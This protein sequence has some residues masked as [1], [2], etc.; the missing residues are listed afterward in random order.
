MCGYPN[1]PSSS[2]GRH[3]RR[4][5]GGGGGSASSAN[6]QLMHPPPPPPQ[7]Q[8]PSNGPPFPASL[9]SRGPA[10]PRG[11]IGPPPALGVGPP[12]ANGSNSNGNSA[13]PMH[14]MSP[15]PSM[16]MQPMP[17]PAFGGHHHHNGPPMMM[18]N[19]MSG[20]LPTAHATLGHAVTWGGGGPPP[21]PHH[22]GMME[23]GPG[24]MVGPMPPP[25]MMMMSG[26][27]EYHHP[28]PADPHYGYMMEAGGP[29]P[30]GPGGPLRSTSVPM[31]AGGGGMPPANNPVNQSHGNTWIQVMQQHSMCPALLNQNDHPTLLRWDPFEDL[32]WVGTQ[33]GRLASMQFTANGGLTDYTRF[34]LE[35]SILDEGCDGESGGCYSPVSNGGVVATYNPVQ[36]LLFDQS[37]VISVTPH[38]IHFHTRGGVRHY[39]MDDKT[40]HR[41]GSNGNVIRSAEFYQPNPSHLVVGGEK[42]T[43]FFVDMQAGSL[44][45]FID[46]PHGCSVL[47]NP[48]RSSVL[49]MGGTDGSISFVDGRVPKVLT[50]LNAH[51]REITTLSSRDHWLI[52]C[53]KREGPGSIVGPDVFLKVFDI[54]TLRQALPISCP[55]GAYMAK[56]HPALPSSVVLLNV[57][58]M[59]QQADF[60]PGASQL[61][62]P[63]YYKT[64]AVGHPRGY[65]NTV[66]ARSSMSDSSTVGSCGDGVGSSSSGG[67]KEV[68]GE[69]IDMDIAS[70]GGT[71]ALLDNNGWIHL[72]QTVSE[73]AMQSQGMHARVNQYSNPTAPHNPRSR[74][75]VTGMLDG[76]TDNRVLAE[77]ARAVRQRPMCVMDRRT[78]NIIYN[79]QDTMPLWPVGLQPMADDEE[80]RQYNN[81]PGAYYDDEQDGCRRLRPPQ[82]MLPAV[83]DAARGQGIDTTKHPDSPRAASRIPVVHMRRS[84]TD[85]PIEGDTI[86]W[87]TTT[88]MNEVSEELR[89]M[90]RD[91]RH[92]QPRAESQLSD[93]LTESAEEEKDPVTGLTRIPRRFQFTEIDYG[94]NYNRFPFAKYNRSRFVCGLDN[95]YGGSNWN[96]IEFC[97]N[98]VTHI[99]YFIRPLMQAAEKHVCT[100]VVCVYCELGYVFRMMEQLMFASNRICQC[101]RLLR[102]LKATAP[103]ELREPIDSNHPALS[104]GHK[105]ILLLKHV[106]LSCKRT[107]S[108][109]P[110]SRGSSPLPSGY[111]PPLSAI[112]HHPSANIVSRLFGLSPPH[113]VPASPFVTLQ[114]PSDEELQE[115]VE[116]C[117]DA[118]AA[119]ATS[120]EEDE[121]GEPHG[122]TTQESDSGEGETDTDGGTHGEAATEDSDEADDGHVLKPDHAAFVSMLRPSLVGGHGSPPVLLMDICP[123]TETQAAFW[124]VGGRDFLPTTLWLGYNDP[125]DRTLITDVS[126][127]KPY[128]ISAKNNNSN[129][130]PRPR[131]NY[132][133]YELQSVAL[134]VKDRPKRKCPQ[135]HLV[136]IT[137]IPPDYHTDTYRTSGTAR[138]PSM[139]SSARGPPPPAEG[140]AAVGAGVGVAGTPAGVGVIPTPPKGTPTRFMSPGVISHPSP[141]YQAS[142][143]SSQ[144]PRPFSYA[145]AVAGRSYAAAASSVGSGA[146]S[147][148]GDSVSPSPPTSEGATSTEEDEEED[149]NWMVLND[150][151]IT[152]SARQE[153]VDFGPEWRTPVLAVYVQKRSLA[154]VAVHDRQLSTATPLSS[155]TLHPDG[156]G[157]KWGQYLLVVI[158]V[159][160][161]SS[162]TIASTLILSPPRITRNF[163]PLTEK[164]IDRLLHGGLTVA[165]DAEFVAMGLASVEIRED[166]SKEVS[167]PGEMA[168]GRVSVLRADPMNPDDGDEGIKEG[169]PFIDHYLRIDESE[170]KDFVTR[171]SG[172]VPGDL[173]PKTSRHWLVSSKSVC[174][175]LRFLVDCGC[176][177]VGHGLSTDFR[178]INL[179]V[180]QRNIRDTVELF[181]LPGQRY[182]SLKFLA[183]HL[184]GSSIQTD[185]HCSVEDA[186]AAL[187]LYRKYQELEAEGTLDDKIKQLYEIGRQQGWK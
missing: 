118:E 42:R 111:S 27:D 52:S 159:W 121:E 51:P 31:M 114:L 28:P 12:P 174:E 74:H 161:C 96:G 150:F 79:Y 146:G 105:G 154:Q 4:P 126:T 138:G 160:R 36:H 131:G 58:G 168:V 125:H 25:R 18:G 39:I 3:H 43:L 20:P 13:G 63:A 9:Y 155:A 144:I 64:V 95:S 112:R 8:M 152:P 30:N 172:L 50:T 82:M 124:S 107:A 24:G 116:R 123:R 41:M 163:V 93:I 44:S 186:R 38:S 175:K 173:D 127:T 78:N 157:L 34:Q 54:R 47:H 119:A 102:T 21:L 40:I 113:G 120:T 178:I 153:A 23:P 80:Q 91:R 158:A 103:A 48:Q 166:G 137:N 69:V 130:L 181:H 33:Q 180:P 55:T 72:W 185:T 141:T 68:M 90:R 15:S 85:P 139:S 165:L 98:A 65:K 140:A 14:T 45:T 110:S 177:F 87:H 183:Q 71:A 37:G 171:F 62:S 99:L 142:L 128:S 89:T 129:A 84:A 149:S 53:G 143:S 60:V 145:A 88:L 32:L 132:Y 104:M 2:H 148:H 1:R 81:L 19:P 29:A 133:K 35:R 46:V 5:S 169:T 179:F 176:R 66:I 109:S 16:H 26:M 115:A 22:Q 100:E 86:L 17:M 76:S 164:E 101:T 6:T 147:G 73:N 49:C 184:L 94:Q 97:N 135:G 106:L 122:E 56:F 187:Q 61:M 59:W 136:G 10:S 92:R 156:V 134:H 182:L 11:Y 108:S 167:S 77:E 57:H 67:G 151:V 75:L 170:I 7:T 117:R 70:T 162:R 83:K